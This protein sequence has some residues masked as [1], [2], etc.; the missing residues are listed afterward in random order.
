MGHLVR[1]EHLF[2]AALVQR[3]EGHHRQVHVSRKGLPIEERDL[4]CVIRMEQ[5]RPV[6]VREEPEAVRD[7]PTHIRSRVVLSEQQ[8]AQLPVRIAIHLDRNRRDAG[9][10][11][12]EF[13]ELSQVEAHLVRRP[14]RDPMG[15]LHVP[16]HAGLHQLADACQSVP[17]RGVEGQVHLG[18]L[19]G[20]TVAREPPRRRLDEQPLIER[21]REPRVPLRRHKPLHDRAESDQ[22]TVPGDPDRP[23]PPGV[24]LRAQP[25]P[26]LGA[27]L[28]AVEGV[29]ATCVAPDG[30]HG[31]LGEQPQ[32]DPSEPCAPGRQANGGRRGE[33]ETLGDRGVDPVRL[34]CE[35]PTAP[36]RHRRRVDA[37]PFTRKLRNDLVVL[38]PLAPAAEQLDLLLLFGIHDE[39]QILAALALDVSE[40]KPVRLSVQE[41]RHERGFL[42]RARPTVEQ[43]V[44]C[45]VQ[46]PSGIAIDDARL[47]GELALQLGRA[48]IGEDEG[49]GDDPGIQRGVTEHALQLS[50]LDDR[51][52]NER[53][54]TLPDENGTDRPPGHR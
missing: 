4:R 40:E 39:H 16:V 15:R 35:W 44:Q 24:E 36:L 14:L 29:R 12:L 52:G 26:Q 34:D 33:V 13:F 8:L 32:L 54:G 21:R 20:E 43:T 23:R 25:D 19:R 10:G 17:L 42:D 5:G 30:I 50:P 3:L 9:P 18:R 6:H 27:A 7:V 45:V 1:A 48:R 47:E 49:G 53:D 38:P 41:R 37:I 11:D 2:T 46:H 31:Q 51:G 28:G 22:I